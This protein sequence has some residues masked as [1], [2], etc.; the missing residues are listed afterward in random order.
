MP[1][2]QIGHLFIAV[3]RQIIGLNRK[4]L[5]LSIENVYL[6]LFGI[7]KAFL[8]EILLRAFQLLRDK[9]AFFVADEMPGH[10]VVDEMVVGQRVVMEKAD[11][12]QG[13]GQKATSNERVR[14]CLDAHRVIIKPNNLID[15][16]FTVRDFGFAPPLLP[17]C[18][19]SEFTIVV[20]GNRIK[21]TVVILGD[22][23]GL[24]ILRLITTDQLFEAQDSRI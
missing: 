8:W 16:N 9:V 18:P 11:K 2:I 19:Q 15:F 5:P 23:V 24:D 17:E 3:I 13:V 14:K 22:L 20:I 7:I 10:D 1:Q 12:D 6:I 4:D 21:S